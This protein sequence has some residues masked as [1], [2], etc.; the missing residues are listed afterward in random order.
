MWY[1]SS[2]HRAATVI[3]VCSSQH[4]CVLLLQKLHH[5]MPELEKT[6]AVAV[7]KMKLEEAA[8][9]KLEERL[10]T[11]RKAAASV[12]TLHN[13]LISPKD[14]NSSWKNKM[15]PSGL[16]TTGVCNCRKSACTKIIR[17]K[18]CAALSHAHS[19]PISQRKLQLQQMYCSITWSSKTSM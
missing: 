17:Y 16:S 19:P 1:S 6:A 13:P 4:G 3:L 11:V 15:S 14:S 18:Y 12:A 5:M 8:R 7:E 9:R 10:I 2:V